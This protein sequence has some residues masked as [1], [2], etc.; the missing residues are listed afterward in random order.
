VLV[1]EVVVAVLVVFA[2]AAIAAGR[3]G[4]LFRPARD[5]PDSGIPDD[6]ALRA[7]DV[8]RLTFRL[9]LRGYRMDDV[10]R[11]LARLRSALADLEGENA[12]LRRQPRPS[13][14]R[15]S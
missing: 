3:G 6:R 2:V 15:R 11:A 14:D 10:D 5:A 4:V 7:D 12:E 1:V 13:A 8:G 9:A